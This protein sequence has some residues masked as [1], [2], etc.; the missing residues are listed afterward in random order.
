M[1]KN[2]TMGLSEAGHRLLY[3]SKGLAGE[4]AIVDLD[5]DVEMHVAGQV[6]YCGVSLH[7]GGCAWQI[8]TTTIGWGTCTGGELLGRRVT[9]SHGP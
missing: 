3:L 5:A 8:Y 7:A 6:S 4:P 9:V 2:G 1:Q